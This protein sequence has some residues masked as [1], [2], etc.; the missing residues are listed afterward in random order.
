M[1]VNVVDQEVDQPIDRDPNAHIQ[2]PALGGGK[3]YNVG[4]GARD[5][6]DQKEKVVFFKEAFL[7]MMRLVVI[8]V[9]YPKESVHQVFVSRPCCEL[10]EDYGGKYDSNIQ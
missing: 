10:H 6:E 7:L 8:F 5:S 9:P 3:A 2:Q 1:N 4:N